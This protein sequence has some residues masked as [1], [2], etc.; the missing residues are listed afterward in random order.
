VGDDVTEDHDRAAVFI[1]G[2]QRHET[3]GPD[4]GN[5]DPSTGDIL[6]RVSLAGPGDVDDA[7]RS[8]SQAAS[9]W[10]AVPPDAR[11]AVLHRLA[12]LIRDRAQQVGRLGALEA[13]VPIRSSLGQAHRSAEFVDYNAGW[14]DKLGGAQ[15]PALGGDALQYTLQEPYGV[16]A[17]FASWNGHSGIWRKAA[18]ALAA[19]NAVVLKLSDLTPTLGVWYAE[20]ASEAGVPDGV[21]NVVAGDAVAGAHLAGHPGVDKIAFTGGL[22]TARLVMAAAAQ[23]V[24]PVL[25]EL[26]GKSPMIVFDDV[27]PVVAGTQALRGCMALSGQGCI[28]PTRLL[29]ARPIYGEVLDAVVTAANALRIGPAIDPSTDMGPVISEASLERILGVIEDASAEGARL[30]TGG[31]RGDGPLATGSFVLPTVFADVD[32]QSSLAQVEV[33]GPVLAVLAF[34]TE[35]EAV[36]LTN[37]TPYGLAGYVFSNDV[38]RLGRVGRR[39]EVGSLGLNCVSGVDP[40]APFGGMRT[41]GVGRE[42]GPEGILEYVRTKHVRLPDLA[43]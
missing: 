26:G 24:K 12:D 28:N 6:G 32:N 40:N 27:D 29:V 10:R 8:A 30:V 18:P 25:F 13:G 7:V 42:G 21:L 5:I 9:V 38:G 14:V 15:I 35:E 39:L 3:G 34:D 4:A 37:G 41:S 22:P 20:L 16:I 31:R 19:G 43:P 1:D 17:A 33:F 2:K 23:R 36:E 11:R